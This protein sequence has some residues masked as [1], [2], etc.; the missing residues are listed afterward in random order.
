MTAAVLDANGGTRR[1]HHE[2]RCLTFSGKPQDV[3]WA[4][5]MNQHAKRR[6]QA[7]ITAEAERAERM[8]P[9]EPKLPTAPLA[10]PETGAT[11]Y[12]ITPEEAGQRLDKVLAARA[13][14]AAIA[15]SRTRL[16]ALIEEGRVQVDGKTA[17][18]AGAKARVGQVVTVDVPPP[19]PAEPRGEN[20]PDPGK[21]FSLFKL[22]RMLAQTV[23]MMGVRCYS[24]S[25]SKC[26]LYAKRRGTYF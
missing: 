21:V 14:A 19:L 4:C 24:T 18:D 7:G 10:T 25:P 20:I 16:R 2:K 12:E 6:Y 9:K 22:H 1:T 13:E 5:L 17:T 11:V 3:L 15:L 23:S 8:R 26:D